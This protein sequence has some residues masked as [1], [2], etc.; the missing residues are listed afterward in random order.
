MVGQLPAIN[1]PSGFL[2]LNADGVFGDR[3]V[4]LK[5]I[6]NGLKRLLGDADA[7]VIDSIKETDDWVSAFP[8]HAASPF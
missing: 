1:V 4:S 7:F 6:G 3:G 5:S 2:R 8:G